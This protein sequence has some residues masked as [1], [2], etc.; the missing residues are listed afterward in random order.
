MRVVRLTSQVNSCDGVLELN[1]LIDTLAGIMAKKPT[2]VACIHDCARMPFPEKASALEL[3][4]TCKTH[5]DYV[6][7]TAKGELLGLRLLQAGT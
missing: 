4:Y 1:T 5:A 7:H 3:G 6:C 2:G